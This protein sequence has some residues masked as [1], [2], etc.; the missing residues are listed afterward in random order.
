VWVPGHV[1]RTETEAGASG[2]I[3]VAH[4]NHLGL[5]ACGWLLR[6]TLDKV[7]TREAVALWRLLIPGSN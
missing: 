4:D 5:L 7:N 6:H 2:G 1:D 3:G